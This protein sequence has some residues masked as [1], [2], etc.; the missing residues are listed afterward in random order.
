MTDKEELHVHF[1]EY[2][3]YIE[4]RVD[5]YIQN[6]VK[7]DRE[8]ANLLI[9]LRK[10]GCSI[11]TIMNA[12]LSVRERWFEKAGLLALE[13]DFSS[14]ISKRNERNKEKKPITSAITKLSGLPLLPGKTPLDHAIHLKVNQTVLKMRQ[15]LMEFKQILDEYLRELHSTEPVQSLDVT[16]SDPYLELV[17]R[18]HPNIYNMFYD[19]EHPGKT[20]T[21]VRLDQSRRGLW[22]EAILGIVDE[23]LRVR[24]SETQAFKKTGRLLRLFYPKYFTDDNYRKVRRIYKYHKSRR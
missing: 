2:A 11:C 4:F 6:N 15:A 9:A 12:V 17:L 5:Q 24:I 20:S 19:N 14:T 18:Q 8:A 16:L 7:P 21:T 13:T 3:S 1:T 10:E 22:K 23:L